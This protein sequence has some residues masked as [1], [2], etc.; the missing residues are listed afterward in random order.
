[1]L[2]EM[3][4]QHRKKLETIRDTLEVIEYAVCKGCCGFKEGRK[5]VYSGCRGRPHEEG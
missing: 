1:M 2:L 3:K 5:Q 4:L